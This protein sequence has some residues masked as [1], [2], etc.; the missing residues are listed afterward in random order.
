MALMT[1]QDIAGRLVALCREGKFEAAQK[2]LFAADAVSIEERETPGFKKETKGLDAIFEKGRV[3][4]ASVD[5]VHSIEVS[6]PL[7][8]GG[9]IAFRLAMDVTMKGKGRVR[10]EELCIYGV[11]DAKI[12]SETFRT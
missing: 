7:V 2:E 10:L 3:F 1:T 12:V 4:S 8:S 9:A 11:K 5:K 6:D